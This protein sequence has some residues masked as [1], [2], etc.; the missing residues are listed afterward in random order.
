MK[1]KH[2]LFCFILL[3]ATGTAYCQDNDLGIWYE[4]NAAK[5]LSK[6]IDLST[7]AVIRTF[8]NGSKIEQGYL[9]IGASCDINK[10]F[11]AAVS[12][13][14]IDFFEKDDQ[15]HIRHKWFADLKGSLPVTNFV[16]SLRLRYEIQMRSYYKHESDR[17]PEYTGRLKFRGLYRT[18][19]FP[20]NPYAGIE[21]FSLVFSDSHLLVD[22][23]R[24]TLGAEYKIK[25]KNSVSA[26]YLLDRDFSPH[27]RNMNIISLSYNLR[28]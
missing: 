19:G 16:F 13:R 14:L 1:I 25:K 23:I 28:F 2:L 6:K 17:R 27:I 4:M 26:E 15:Y 21:T 7:S 9:E 11:S 20:V 22:K 10:Y 3:S 12:Y 18:P 5:S 8:N 24:Y